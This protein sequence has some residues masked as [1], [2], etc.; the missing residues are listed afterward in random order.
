[1]IHDVHHSDFN[2]QLHTALKKAKMASICTQHIY[3]MVWVLATTCT[4]M[5]TGAWQLH[6]LSA[7]SALRSLRLVHAGGLLGQVQ[8]LREGNTHVVNKQD[9]TLCM[10]C[11]HTQHWTAEQSKRPAKKRLTGV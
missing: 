7:S 1:M 4:A 9:R 3:H 2:A 5:M 6:H 11:T 8:L 10:R